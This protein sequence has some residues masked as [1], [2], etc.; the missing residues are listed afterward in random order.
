MNFGDRLARLDAMFGVGAAV[1]DLGIHTVRVENLRNGIFCVAVP[2]DHTGRTQVQRRKLSPLGAELRHGGQLVLESPHHLTLVRKRNRR[3][4]NIRKVFRP[5]LRGRF[6][7]QGTECSDR[8]AVGHNDS[9]LQQHKRGL[10][11][12]H[13]AVNAPSAPPAEKPRE[14]SL[15]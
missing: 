11:K 6:A 9:R 8:K 15:L 1:D 2:Q 3:H 5:Y 10:A 4:Q 12:K 7:M 14:E 13:L